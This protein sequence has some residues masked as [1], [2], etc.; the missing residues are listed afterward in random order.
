MPW[1]QILQYHVRPKTYWANLLNR[2]LLVR[3][4][5]VARRVHLL[6]AWVLGKALS[7]MLGDSS[8]NPA[9]EHH[10]FVEVETNSNATHTTLPTKHPLSDNS[11]GPPFPLALRVIMIFPLVL[12]YKYTRPRKGKGC[13]KSKRRVSCL[14]G[15]LQR[16]KGEQSRDCRNIA[17]S[18]S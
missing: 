6:C 2:Y 18:L 16:V 1:E 10:P 15:E 11:I 5:E 3:S 7:W 4:Q 8:E 13:W 17:G 9:T 12:N 14:D